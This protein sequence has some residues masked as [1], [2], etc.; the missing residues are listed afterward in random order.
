M[1]RDMARQQVAARLLTHLLRGALANHRP[2]RHGPGRHDE[3]AVAM[4]T[5]LGLQETTTD[6]RSWSEPAADEVVYMVDYDEELR[7]ALDHVVIS[8]GLRT[9]LFSS[10]EALVAH[11]LPERPSCLILDLHRG[12]RGGGLDLQARLGDRQH[13]LPIV[14]M[15]EPGDIRGAVRAMK[16]GAV[17]VLERPI[18]PETLHAS[19]RSALALSRENLRVCAEQQRVL[20]RFELLTRRERQLLWLIVRGGLSNRQMAEEMGAAEKTI[21]V[22]R[23]HLT[24]KMQANSVADLVRMTEFLPRQDRVDVVIHRMRH[25]P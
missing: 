24:R 4:F 23:G 10:A 2:L 15:S 6:H 16:A 17:D 5:H 9:R 13:I 20:G 8:T 18:D 14:F 1:R 25:A 12:S 21:K 22:H 11:T 3:R 19:V 7:R